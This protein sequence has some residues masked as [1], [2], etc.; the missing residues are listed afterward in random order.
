MSKKILDACCGP[1]MFWFDKAHLDVLYQDIR[2]FDGVVYDKKIKVAPDTIA[3]FR[4][5]PYPDETFY[6]VVFDPPHLK[7]AGKESRMRAAYGQLDHKTW[8]DDISKGFEECF[9]VLKPNG[10]LVFKWSDCQIKLKDV[11]ALAP[12]KPLFG[13]RS[14]KTAHWMVFMKTDVPD[15][16][17]WD[18]DRSKK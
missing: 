8:K 11:L 13:N 17:A 7:W 16:P 18:F 1:R 10:V 2:E 14:G 5:M 3:D 15:D 9:R 4:N 12:Q 6:L